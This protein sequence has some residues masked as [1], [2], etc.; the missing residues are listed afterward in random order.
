MLNVIKAQI[1]GLLQPPNDEIQGPRLY[2]AQP[3]GEQRKAVSL[4][5]K[6]LHQLHR[7]CLL[8]SY[9]QSPPGNPSHL[10]HCRPEILCLR[11]AFERAAS[12]RPNVPLQQELQERKQV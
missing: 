12:G 1:R 4:R 5:K 3:R 2:L 9:A 6:S 7:L 10:P 11:E 8:V